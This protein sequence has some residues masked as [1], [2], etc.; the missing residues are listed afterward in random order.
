MLGVLAVLAILATVLL[1]SLI[2]E[3]DKLAADPARERQSA[4]LL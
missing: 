4:S 3:A 2:R 1:P